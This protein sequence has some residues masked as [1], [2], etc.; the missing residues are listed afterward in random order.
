MAVLLNELFFPKADPSTTAIYSAT[1]FCSTF[2]FR[3]IGALIFGWLG[4]NI[5]R[6][7]TV[8]VTTFMMAITCV[9]MAII[10][11]YAEKGIIA[12][13]LVTMCRIIQGM[14]SMGEAI[15]AELY[16]TETISPPAQYPAV[17]MVSVFVA[18]GMMAA[19]GF[20]TLITSNGINWRYAFWIGAIVAIIGI[21]ARTALRET[22]DFSNAK[23]RI[24][25]AL[26]KA[27]YDT[28]IVENSLAW[29]KKASKKTALSLFLIQCSWPACFYFVYFYCGNILTNNFG[30]SAEQ[31]IS[32]NFILSI[33]QLVSVIS[34]AYLSYYI[35]PLKIVRAKLII[36]SLLTLLCPYILNNITSAY[37]LLIFQAIFI[38]LIS[39]SVPAVPIFFKHFPV[40]KRFT[41]TS[42]SY[43]L[44][45][46]LIYI[47]T[48]FGFAYVVK[49]FGNW[50]ILTI[51][52][53]INLGFALGLNH[54]EKL[55]KE[56]HSHH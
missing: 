11:T 6:K 19:V 51:L 10:P 52:M 55:E 3:P 5:G 53:P 49:Y 24:K 15:G 26:E 31:V 12:T 45:R 18:F 8:V 9:M 32:H 7:S 33:I 4:D 1:A 17:T 28:K 56:A 36:F 40:F 14:A 23:R 21:A 41:Y 39:S 54:F 27:N 30:Y 43:A 46:A 44:S 22:A 13:L 48:S 25:L 34:L 29:N 20:A 50:G 37:N 38:L 42:V 47:I 16:L 2:V 35:N